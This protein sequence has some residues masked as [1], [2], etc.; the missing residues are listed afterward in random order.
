MVSVLTGCRRWGEDGKR[1]SSRPVEGHDLSGGSWSTLRHGGTHVEFLPLNEIR[2]LERGMMIDPWLYQVE[3]NLPHLLSG[4]ERLVRIESPSGDPRRLEASAGELTRAGSDI[5]GVSPEVAS[6]EGSPCVIWRFGAAPRRVL[7]LGHHDTVWPA[8]TLSRIPWSTHDGTIRGPGCFD[9]KTGIVQA[10]H[11]VALVRERYGPLGVDGLSILITGDEETGSKGSRAIIEAEA[12]T[13]SA[14]LVLEA[15]GVGGALKIERKGVSMYRV[16]AKGRASHAGLEPESGV[17][18]SI[19][20]ASHVAAIAAMSD[21]AA[22]TSV[23]PTSLSAGTSTNTVPDR[24]ELAVDVRVRTR[25]EQ[26]RVHREINALKPTLDEAMLEVNGGPNRPPMHVSR[27]QELFGIA[28]D[29]SPR[30]GI[31]GL[32][33]L[34]VGGASDGNFTAGLGIPTLD[35]LGAVGGGAHADSEHVVI[36]QIARRTTLLALLLERLLGCEGT[37]FSRCEVAGEQPINTSTD[38]ISSHNTEEKYAH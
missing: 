34:S 25:E 38:D 26:E 3:N 20:I 6:A 36:D 9:M 11:A 18:A 31:E 35:G 32:I 12:Q 16:V 29:L 37:S 23:T 33:G 5:M 4:I 7:L 19:E 8:G 15:A 27:A 30:A 28:L 2:R 24:A 14:V 1:D 13:C 17:N 10:L 21:P 22:G